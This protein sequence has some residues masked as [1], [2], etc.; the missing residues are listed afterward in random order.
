MKSL[1]IALIVISY[2]MIACESHSN[3]EILLESG[4]LFSYDL[5]VYGDEEGAKITEQAKHY[6]QSEIIRD[7]STGWGAY[8]YYKSVTG[9]S[10]PD[11]VTIETC[12][13]G[14]GTGCDKISTILFEFQ[15][16]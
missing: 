11:H 15:I 14:K 2:L 12:T 10:G 9:Y 3:H 4:E 6:S 13:G 5:N 1:S 7:S 16:E 8:Y